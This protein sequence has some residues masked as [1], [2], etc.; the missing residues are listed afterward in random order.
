MLVMYDSR[1]VS[2]SQIYPKIIQNSFKRFLKA[3]TY[4]A[5]YLPYCSAMYTALPK[6]NLVVYVVM[7]ALLDCCIKQC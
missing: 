5:F 4:Y 3:F 6:D 1:W 2:L 7:N